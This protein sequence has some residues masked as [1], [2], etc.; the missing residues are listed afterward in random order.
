MPDSAKSVPMIAPTPLMR[1]RLF[2]IILSV[3]LAAATGISCI[4]YYYSVSRS[5]YYRAKANSQQLSSYTISANR[6]TIYDR[7]GKIL[8]QSTT[9]WDVVLDPKYISENDSENTEKICRFLSSVAGRNYLDLMSACEDTTKEYYIVK[10]KVDKG[11]RDRIQAFIDENKIKPFSISL[12]ETS[13][14]YY[15]NDSLASSIIGF[16]NYDG[17]GVYGIEAY[18]DDYLQGTDGLIVM[19]KDARGNAMP[20]DYE[21]RYEA[22]DGNSIVLTI[23]EVVQHYLEKNL[24]ITLS[25]HAVAN[26]ATGIVMNVNTG[27]IVAM[28]TAPGYDLNNPSELSEYDKEL[29]VKLR[30]QLVLDYRASEC[31]SVDGALDVASLCCQLLSIDLVAS[32]AFVLVVVVG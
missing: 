1:R 7:K 20:Y 28:A 27:A 13:K 30:E 2:F 31:Q 32:K 5:E 29:L 3:L 15:P 10:K 19:A 17:D 21:N 24:E 9:V 25:Q 8:A 22:S 12:M 6:G 11:I 4:L 16:T 23:D 18:Y 26:R 14:R